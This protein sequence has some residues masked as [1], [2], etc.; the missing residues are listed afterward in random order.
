MRELVFDEIL[1]LVV[2]TIRVYVVALISCFERGWERCREFD[3]E[4]LLLL[5]L[6]QIQR[7]CEATQRFD[8]RNLIITLMRE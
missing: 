6:I 7:V 3:V 8:D 5:L 4:T 1:P 2:T